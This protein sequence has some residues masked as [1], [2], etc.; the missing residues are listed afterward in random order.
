M[1]HAVLSFCDRIQALLHKNLLPIIILVFAGLCGVLMFATPGKSHWLPPCFFHQLTG[2]LCPGCGSTRA[3]H[4]MIHGD[5]LRSLHNNALL[6]P[7]LA[8]ILSLAAFPRLA[9]NRRFVTAVLAIVVAFMILR[10]IPCW[11]FTL[12]APTAY[13]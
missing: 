9:V 3:L 2:I 5:V 11:P 7:A 12:L 6:L 4:A 1:K 10:N 8:V 13:P